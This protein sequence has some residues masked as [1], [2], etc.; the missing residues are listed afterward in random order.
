MLNAYVFESVDQVREIT[1]EWLQSYNEERPQVTTS[2]ESAAQEAV[3]GLTRVHLS[4]HQMR[5][6]ASM[7][8]SG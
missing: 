7:V 6:D 5:P 4:Y 2:S 8:D 3:V 1:A